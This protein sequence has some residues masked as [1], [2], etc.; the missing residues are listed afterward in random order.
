MGG[1]IGNG[2]PIA[3]GWGM[4]NRKPGMGNRDIYLS[5]NSLSPVSIAK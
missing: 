1:E 3:I 5:L 4:G 2:D